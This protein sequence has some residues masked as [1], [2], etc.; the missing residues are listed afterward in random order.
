MKSSVWEKAE[1]FLRERKD[2]KRWLAVVACL[3]VLVTL[4]TVAALKNT[5]SAMT[6]TQEV[7][8]CRY[9]VH[10]H[11]Q[12]CYDAGGN[13]ICGYADVVIHQHN[14]DCYDA[15]GKLVCTLPEVKL[16]K[17]HEASCYTEQ[18]ELVCGLTEGEDHT[19]SDSCYTRNEVLTCTRIAQDLHTH[20]EKC[21]D[22]SGN[23]I[24]GLLQLEEHVH[25][26]DCIETVELN[27][28]EVAALN[29]QNGESEEET[30]MSESAGVGESTFFMEE[31]T[32][33]E[34][35]ETEADAAYEFTQ[36]FTG[37]DYTVV[38][39]Y[40]SDAELPENAVL[41]VREI[42]AGTEEYQQYYDQ[43]M[44]AMGV[45]ELSFA[46]F[47]DIT[48][49]VDGVEIEPATPVDVKI[50]YDDSIEVGENASGSAVHFAEDEDNQTVS[51]EIYEEVLGADGNSFEF[52]QNSFSV[53]GTI[54]AE[55]SGSWTTFSSVGE[56]VKSLV[57]GQQYIL[58]TTRNSKTRAITHNGTSVGT[59]AVTIN[60]STVTANSDDALWT[61]DSSGRFYYTS[62]G[63]TYYLTCSDDA[64]SATTSEK[65]AAAL[66]DSN[67][68]AGKSGDKTYYIRLNEDGDGWTTTKKSDKNGTTFSFAKYTPSSD[69]GKIRVYV[70]V[71][72][73]DTNGNSWRTNAEFQ[74]LIGLYSCDSNAYF[75][76]GEILLDASF[77]EGKNYTTPGAPLL[78]SE[79]DWVE[80]LAALSE[81]D[82]NT[83]S[84]VAGQTPKWSTGEKGT[85][86][87]N[88]GNHVDEYL[89][90]ATQDINCS[91]GSQKSALFRWST[92]TSYGF[93]DQTVQYHLDLNFKTN[94]IT[95]IA[96]NNGLSSDGQTIDTRV[97]I[98]GSEIQEPRNLVVPEGYRFVGYYSDLACT[99][100]WDGIGTPLNE[101]TTVYV[102]LAPEDNVV[103]HYVN[104]TG[105]VA[106]VLSMYDEPLNPVTGVAEGSTATTN[107][108][109]QFSGWYADE[110]CTQ[111]LSSEV[112]YVPKKPA[113]GHWID[114]T[115]YYAK[116]EPIGSVRTL[117]KVWDDNNNEQ[118]LRPESVTFVISG[119]GTIDSEDDQPIVFT[120]ENVTTNED[121]SITADGN[122]QVVLTADDSDIDTPNE[123]RYE[124]NLPDTL[125]VLDSGTTITYAVTEIQVDNYDAAETVFDAEA[126]CYSITNTVWKQAIGLSFYLRLDSTIENANISF[127]GGSGDWTTSVAERILY[128]PNDWAAQG[129]STG[130]V[131]GSNQPG[132][133][134]SQYDKLIRAA[135]GPEGSTAET[136]EGTYYFLPAAPSP[137]VTVETV[138]LSDSEA[139][140]QGTVTIT[141]AAT[142]F[143]TDAEIFANMRSYWTQYTKNQGIEVTVYDPNTGNPIQVEIQPE[144]LTTDNF[145]IYWTVFKRSTNA[146]W[147]VDGLLMPKSGN[148]TISK[149][150][151]TDVTSEV[152]KT[153]AINVSGEWEIGGQSYPHSYTLRLTDD[154]VT[155]TENTDG[156]VTYTWEKIVY[157]S[158]YTFTETGYTT[159]NG[160]TWTGATYSVNDGD[161]TS[162]T[163]TDGVTANISCTTA[164]SG[165]SVAFVNNYQVK[166]KVLKVNSENNQTLVPGAV[167]SVSGEGVP[168]ST[169]WTSD[170]SGVLFRGLLDD[171]DY[172]LTE[173]TAPNGYNL[174]NDR[175]IITIED[176]DVQVSTSSGSNDGLVSI[177]SQLDEDGYTVIRICNKTGYQLPSTGGPGTILYT[178]GGIA[179]L[180]I[181]L[182]YGFSMRRMRERRFK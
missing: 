34:A 39:G 72:G 53:S 17:Q 47:F 167:F 164:K 44:E 170:E 29:A 150:F 66:N 55:K 61:Y 109:Y 137:G 126:K 26:A 129:D 4:G 42:E 96:A 136:D 114:G 106:G 179:I 78:T 154:E 134:A 151:S 24:C 152:E 35:E 131:L 63:T 111:L 88:R 128:D 89:S 21:Y 54:V 174:L 2:Y 77:L 79:A 123:W 140:W 163:S 73:T 118:D 95:F 121:V 91:W 15:E 36:T 101:D 62:N 57:A 18:N 115:T 7:L 93:E 20:N 23:L 22:G 107:L 50:S 19:H 86:E 148:I 16:H 178:L 112:T 180:A 14:D 143:P 141:S 100:P 155:K 117:I 119:T 25:N 10:K 60:G 181:G 133:S 38:V 28:E 146:F 58:Y 105:S 27:D 122:I 125:S 37:A 166:L 8:N 83:L 169:S 176:Y 157:G 45:D 82:T 84:N 182:L 113:A 177:D 51:P 130:I 168:A 120:S 33:A 13:L 64:V 110:A 171:G 76:A 56:S 6:H 161:P 172:T 87:D 147:H 9:E 138:D 162:S 81:M 75:P 74:D 70:Y 30:T 71:A 153:F 108:G 97:Y 124:I 145:E 52:T 135:L 49:L 40:Y 59:V 65:N 90:Q 1:R 41:S 103:L 67:K 92:A 11:T 43:S 69:D 156:S 142:T 104:V 139:P 80:L 158:D 99:I 165:Q 159:Q 48:F 132:N 12:A 175:V 46:R 127:A 3:A 5:G 116:W 98:T 68:I 144:D 31:E 32:T 94:K 102:K 85:F 160:F 149:T 173:T